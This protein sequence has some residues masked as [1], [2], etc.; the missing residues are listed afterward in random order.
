VSGTFTVPSVTAAASCDDTLAEWVGIDGVNN[1]NLI[2]A[3][4]S[5]SMTNPNTGVCVPGET[6][7]WAWWEVLPAFSTPEYGLAV[8]PGDSVTVTIKQISGSTWDINAVDSTDGQVFDTDQPY[9]GPDTSAEWITEA[10]ANSTCTPVAAMSDASGVGV[11]PLAPYAPPVTFSNLSFVGTVTSWD[12][13]TMVQNGVQVS[14]PSPYITD[15]ANE[16]TGFTVSYTD[17]ES[18]GLRAGAGQ[19]TEKFIKTAP[20][21]FRYGYHT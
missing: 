19:I 4:I 14:T 16:V 9:N 21:M 15:S 18:S 5:E 13:M 7:M 8:H 6:S 11:C 20:S 2:Q 17:S 10:Y 12:D 3:G 1:D